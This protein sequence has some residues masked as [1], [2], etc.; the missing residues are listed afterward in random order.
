MGERGTDLLETADR[1]ISELIGLFTA[2]GK[3]ALSLPC[4][5]REPL[6]DG[7][8]AALALHTA[9]SY[10]GSP[11]S[12]KTPTRCPARTLRRCRAV[13]GSHGLSSPA[14]MRLPATAI[15]VTTRALTTTNTWRRTSTLIT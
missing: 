13:T 1:Q 14:A 3:A 10:H 7:T 12:F 9:D 8:V 15:A 6:G 5:G 2:Q 4:P 11:D